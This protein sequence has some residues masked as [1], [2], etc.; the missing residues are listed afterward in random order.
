MVNSTSQYPSSNKV[1]VCKEV[2]G[3]A[4]PDVIVQ[5]ITVELT[6]GSVDDW[7]GHVRHDGRFQQRK[8]PV[9]PGKWRL[10][11]QTM[12]RNETPGGKETAGH[13]EARGAG[14]GHGWAKRRSQPSCD[15]HSHEHPRE[16]CPGH[17]LGRDHD[18]VRICCSNLKE[19]R[20]LQAFPGPGG[21]EPMTA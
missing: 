11:R 5:T 8:C 4:L 16:S 6:N 9:Q 13:H 14:K 12:P 1:T 15:S 21:T 10:R 19:P 3:V 7:I 17:G 20:L 2:T 18:Q